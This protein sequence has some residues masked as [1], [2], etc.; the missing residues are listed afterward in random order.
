MR[1]HIQ[2]YIDEKYFIYTHPSGK[3]A[4]HL[5][6]NKEKINEVYFDTFYHDLPA[7]RILKDISLIFGFDIEEA[8]LEFHI[9]A[10]KNY[11]HI[12]LYFFWDSL[13]TTS[14]NII[15]PSVRQPKINTLGNELI[16]VMPLS[17]P[18]SVLFH[19]DIKLEKDKPDSIFKN[20][21]RSLKKVCG[22]KKTN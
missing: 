5:I 7:N 15:F 13:Q 6:S 1:K 8:K 20:L 21:L 19:T 11:P 10:F 2:R 14:T 9:W 16:S 12:D 17:A 3:D 4:I 18:K 22:K